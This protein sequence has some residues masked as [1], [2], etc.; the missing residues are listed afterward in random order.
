MADS[1]PAVPGPPAAAAPPA[2]L[3]VRAR[4]L[5]PRAVYDYYAGGS[6]TET[7]V[8][9]APLA[10]Q[11]WRLRPRM[12][13]GVT[14]PD[15]R[16]SLLGSPVDAPI[17]VAPWA[18]QRM[19]HPDG[20]LATAAACARTGTLMTVSTTATVP[21]AEVATV[22]PDSPKWFQLYQV[23]GPAYTDDLVLRAAGAGYRALVLTVD[24]PVLGRR[25]RDL[26]NDFQLPEGLV[27]ANHP[28][29]A[30]VTSDAEL[31]AHASAGGSG[32]SVRQLSQALNSAEHTPPWTYADVEHFAGLTDLPVVV[33]G[34]LRGDDALRCLESGAA[35]LWVSTHGGRQVDRAVSSAAALV[36]VVSTV[37]ERA[38]IY[39][40]G[41]IRSGTDA[42]VALALGARAVFCGRPIIWGLATGGED[43]VVSV[44]TNLC[45]ELA[46]TMALCGVTSVERVSRDLVTS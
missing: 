12:L 29:Q 11:R 20:E 4:E 1:E 34:I 21:M 2:D 7:T 27:M 36:D 40:D 9:E 44:L 14:A 16:T 41:G 6:E 32:A 5:L 43:G 38:E 31:P 33:K 8:R 10:W 18:L 3:H 28:D 42:L 30:D 23:H 46:H 39:V 25:L 17:G 13:T 24:L 22:V 15:L 26:V 37:N 35:A 19:A 45:A